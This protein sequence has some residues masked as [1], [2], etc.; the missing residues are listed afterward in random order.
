MTTARPS[1]SIGAP[2][3]RNSVRLEDLADLGIGDIAALPPELLSDLQ[4]AAAEATAHLK[5]LRERLDAGLERR[6]GAQAEAARAEAGKTTGVVRIEDGDFVVVADLPKKV[7]WD[8]AQLARVA[9]RIAAAG[10]DPAGYLEITYR[11]PER[12]FTAWPDALREGF[13]AARTETTARPTFKL[14][15]RGDR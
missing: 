10:E 3:R 8:Q 11:V 7:S 15:P 4:E 14:E 9:E 2:Q 1:T 6:Y 13:V 12:K 5:R